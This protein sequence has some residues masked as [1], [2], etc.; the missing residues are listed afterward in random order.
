MY[1]TRLRFTYSINLLTREMLPGKGIPGMPHLF[2][3]SSRGDKRVTLQLINKLER[4]QSECRE[5]KIN[6]SVAGF[7]FTMWR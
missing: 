7:T 2:Q 3:P 6:G 5:A 1:L 4:L